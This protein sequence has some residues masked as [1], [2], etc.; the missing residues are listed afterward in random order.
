MKKRYIIIP[1]ICA[2]VIGSGVC[3]A[4]TVNSAMETMKTL[5]GSTIEEVKRQNLQDYITASGTLESSDI[6]KIYSDLIYPIESVNVS[7]G[8]V[9][10]KGDILCT[11]DTETLERRISEQEAAMKTSDQNTGYNITDAEKAYNDALADYENGD[12]TQIISAQNALDNA[13]T[14]LDAAQKAYD[15]AKERQGTDKDTQLRSAE[16][17]LAAAKTSLANAEK[18]YKK[19]LD[20]QKDEDYYSIKQVV[21]AYDT[22]KETY[23]TA[24]SHEATTR[25]KDAE[26]AYLQAFENYNYYQTGVLALPEGKSISDMA[27]DLSAKKATWENYIQLYNVPR[28]EKAYD[29]AKE[30]YDKAR[31]QIDKANQNAV[32]Q[33]ESALE[34]AKRQLESAQMQYD[35]T[36]TGNTDTIDKLEDNLENAQIAYNKAKNNY[37]LTVTA[38]LDSLDTLKTQ[39]QRARDR[40]DNTSAQV[41][42]QN[43]YDQLEEAT[44]TAPVDGVITYENVMEGIAP[45]GVLF[46]IEDVSDLLINV[47]VSEY[48]VV[49]VTPDMKCEI[50]PNAMTDLIYDGVIRK[51]APAAAKTPTGDD[52]GAGAFEAT[53][54]VT[55][56]DTALL[57]G[58][59]AR[60]NIIIEE[61]KD[62]LVVSSDVIL[63]DE[64]GSYVFEAVGSGENYTYTAKKLYVNTGMETSFYVEIT[65]VN[66]GEI[67]EG[68]KLLTRPQNLTDGQIVTVLPDGMMDALAG[69]Y[70]T[71]AVN[72]SVN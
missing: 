48:D 63:T 65:P 3:I 6:N 31:D 25:I 50:I 34:A 10:K 45:T 70:P 47:G 68:T 39:A 5:G 59:T 24:R 27:A 58:M 38:V 29:E 46:V 57:I 53:I 16:L 64:E 49:N 56:R 1:I 72:V 62:V 30:A 7:V 51:V 19:A 37:D 42:L 61:K 15:D 52:A 20:T 41:A 44:I 12:N 67:D 23:D 69:G 22:A 13:E 11:I 4:A 26:S 21:D 33:T 35:A 60:I 66:A 2:V 28:A 18:A 40:S 9:V 55:S 17:S 54:A 14:A 36:L 8:D 71:P 43:L 32:D